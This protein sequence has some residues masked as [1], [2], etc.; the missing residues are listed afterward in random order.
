MRWLAL[1]LTCATLAWGKPPASDAARPG[2]RLIYS[3][4]PAPKSLNYYLDCNV[5]SRQV[6]GLMYDSLLSDD[7][8]TAEPARGLAES[9]EVSED[10]RDFTFQ[11]DPAAKWSDGR[12]LTADDVA[13]T[14]H[15][16]I[17]PGSMTGPFKVEL[18]V[19]EPP[20]I[21]SPRTIRFRA[22]TVHWRNLLAVGNL[23]ILPKHIFGGKDFNKINFTF[24]VVSGPYRLAKLDEGASI[25]MQRR[26]DWWAQGRP[27]NRGVYNFD[28]ILF[29]HFSDPIN[30]FESFKKGETDI[31]P[32]TISR[33]WN[34]EAQ[35]VEFDANRIRRLRVRNQNP[36]GFQGFAMNLRKAPFDE[37]PVRQAFAHLLDRALLNKTLMHGAYFLQKSYFEDLYDAAHPCRNPTFDY[38]PEKASALLDGAGYMRG[39]DGYRYR[40]GRRLCFEFLSR[41]GSA[42]NILAFYSA[43]LRKAGIEMKIVRKDFAA[44]M[45]DMDAFNFQMT[46]AA[47]SSGLY[48]DPESMWSS[49]QADNQG[50]NN[51]TGFRDA[52]V[53]ALI[54][55]QKRIFSLEERNGI[56]REIDRLVTAQV[57]YVLLWNTDATRLLFWNKFGLPRQPLGRFG[58]EAAI[59]A[60]WWFDPD[61]AAEL[62]D[63]R[64]YNIPMPAEAVE[65]RYTDSAA[66]GQAIDGQAVRP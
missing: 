6:F 8:I 10:K 2:G 19:F 49:A 30:A 36:I 22:K 44:W 9:W 3:A 1:F 37:L 45:R 58:D 31:Y 55:R 59:V 12:P 11:L 43:A 47:W 40:N 7:P 21:L 48:K 41:D 17:A 53:D 39:K 13:F 52:Q 27:E 34:V 16:L 5:F 51:I 26:G 66:S 56:C 50:G 60:Y 62:A 63:S 54:E 46:W 57:P 20:E 25:L 29:R 18:S 64:A 28:Q 14:F 38:N 35:G 24:P 15:A 23:P 32:V 33:I 65:S 4:P 42:D 61:T